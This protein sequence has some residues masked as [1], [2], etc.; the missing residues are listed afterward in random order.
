MS[1]TLT[2]VLIML[3]TAAGSSDEAASREKAERYQ[4]S[5][6]STKCSDIQSVEEHPSIPE[7]FVLAKVLEERAWLIGGSCPEKIVLLDMHARIGLTQ[8]EMKQVKTV[9][10]ESGC[11][12]VEGSEESHAAYLNP[13]KEDWDFNRLEGAIA[14]TLSVCFTNA[15]DLKITVGWYKGLLS[16]KARVWRFTWDGTEWKERREVIIRVS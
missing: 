9:L 4:S 2:G 8:L 13:D 14:A 11:V 10:E 15:G 7:G 6:E 1:V 3:A 16:A 5:Y 12:V